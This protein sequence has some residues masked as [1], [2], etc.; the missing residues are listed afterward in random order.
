[1]MMGTLK[2]FPNPPATGPVEQSST[3]SHA[4]GRRP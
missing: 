4:T 3:G 2:G 1:M